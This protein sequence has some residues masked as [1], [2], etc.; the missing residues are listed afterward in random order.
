VARLIDW[1]RRQPAEAWV[2][3]FLVLA[4][5][6]FVFSQLQPVLLFKDTT[7]AGGD[8]GAHVWA[9]AFLREHLLPNLQLSGWAPDW[10]AG[11]PVYVFYMVVPSLL[12]VF[13]NVVL[14]VPYNV[15]FKLVSVSGLLAMPLAGW[16]L[17][18]LA[19]LPFPYPAV[20]AVATVPFVFE[21]SFTI[22]GGNAAST[23]A[24]EFAF[25]I[26]LALSLVF[27][28]V[29][30]RGLD[31]GKSRAA[32]AILLALTVT[33]HLIPAI[34]ALVAAALILGFSIGWTWVGAAIALGVAA[35]GGLVVLLL[36]ALPPVVGV[37]VVL[38]VGAVVA[39]F[40]S[41]RNELLGRLG[42]ARLRVWW[43]VSALGT[44][45]LLTCFWTLPFV[46][47]RRYMTDMGW[48]KVTNYLQL[49][50][51]GRIGDRAAHVWNGIS[52]TFGGESHQIVDGAVSG[53]MTW[54]IVLAAVGIGTSIAFRRRFGLWLATT[55]GVLALLVVLAPQ[56][57]LWNARI[58]PFWY[59][60]LYFLAAV[61]IIE[62]IGALSVLL[63]KDGAPRRGVLVG[64]PVLMALFTAAFVA[65]PLWA[66]PGGSISTASDGTQKYSWL[67]LSTKDH[68]FV[69][70]WAKWNYSGYE[71]KD[72]YPEYQDVVSAMDRLGEERGCGR[73]MW[74]YEKELDRFG[75]PMA[76]MLLPYWTEGCIGSMEGL[77]FEASATT[78]YHFLN[79]SE[80]STAPSRAKR[81]IPYGALDVELGVNHLQLLGVKYYMAFSDAAIAEADVNPNL[82]L[83]A[84][85][86]A[87][88]VYEVANAELVQPL[89]NEPAVVKGM[90]KGG[91]TWQDMA[92][93]WYLDRS[94]WPVV[95]AADGPSPWQRIE[96][97]EEPIE[98]GYSDTTVTDIEAKEGSI[99]FTVDRTGAPILVKAS[100]FPNWKAKNAEG[101][102]RVAP[103][104]MVVVP[105]DNL[106]ELT[107]ERTTIDWLA[108]LLTAGG[109]ALTI[110]MGRRR[111]LR[112]PP[113]L[114]RQRPEAPTT[115]VDEA[116][117]TVG[118]AKPDRE[119]WGPPPE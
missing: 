109:I 6:A 3:A 77:F 52:T 85:T 118:E 27:L 56:G 22:Y 20:L 53:D 5:T 42:D 10:Y 70:S 58:L 102:F 84:T 18:R 32:A 38:A 96:A 119:R 94:E 80:L 46:M 105:T 108:L 37:V 44:G 99:K 36:L 66:L 17:G 14:F 65:F 25:S 4:S 86:G 104:L 88:H 92:V 71:K 95:R 12:I 115:N 110:M 76:L 82:K 2:T 19:R 81:D 26:S 107:Y 97:D 63:A 40:W 55:G 47:S 51:P 61:A 30:H 21:R 114:P 35:I 24:G 13:V 50:F 98:R 8:M 9:P 116:F 113:R 117:A 39:R 91:E 68:S 45:A 1:L 106:V 79:Q 49:L 103:N 90:A 23:L 31:T 59:L 54:V 64:G 72:A 29:V 78:P 112:I 75:T 15:A 43:F 57:K 60:V 67:F 7:P 111:R 101:P 11:F 41:R 100:Y 74:E 33:C 93:D 89:D 34:F 62:L 16:S 73:A 69:P 28:G 48:E 87:W 83:A